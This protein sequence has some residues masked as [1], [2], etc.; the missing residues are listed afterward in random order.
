MTDHKPLVT[1]NNLKNPIGRT[2]RLLN[3]LEGST[4]EFKYCPGR[5]NHLAD[6]LSRS[7]HQDDP[8]SSKQNMAFIEKRC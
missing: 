4:F 5:L 2:A 7:D 8:V 3:Q 6:Y 1:L